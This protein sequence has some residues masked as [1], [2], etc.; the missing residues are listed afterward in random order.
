MAPSDAEA[1]IEDKPLL[2]GASP[3]TLSPGYIA[4]SNPEEDP[5]EDPKEDPA[6]Y[7]ADE[8]DDA[9]DESFDDDDDDDE[10]EASKDD[11]EEAEEHPALADSSTVPADDP[12]PSAEDIESFENDESA[13]TLV[14]SPGLRTARMFFRPQPLMSATAEV[15][16]AKYASAPTSPSPLPSPLTPISSPLPQIPSPPLP[17]PSP[18]TTRPIYAEAPLGY[19]AAGI[20]LRAA[21]LSIH[22]PS[23]IPSLSLLLPSTTH[24]DDLPKVDMP[25]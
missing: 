2:D 8:G 4:D 25:L 15:L 24:R 10:Q 3:T 16:I 9:D 21:S 13:P 12:I 23:K 22:H 7:H 17:L 20:Q 5:E 1:P 11:D 14:P 19:I 18:S 6:D